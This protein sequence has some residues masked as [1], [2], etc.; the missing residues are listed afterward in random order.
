[1]A[2]QL[3][4]HTL[5]DIASIPNRLGEF[6]WETLRPGVDICKLHQDFAGNTKMA[7][8]RYIPGATVPEHLHVGMEY[9]QVLSGSQQDERGIYP[10]GTVVINRT[11][12][13]HSVASPEGCVVLAIWEVPVR[14]L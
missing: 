3:D 6:V 9:I 10:A 11:G 13:K 5:T 14:F 4:L 2:R 7:L 8:L 1:M 12:S